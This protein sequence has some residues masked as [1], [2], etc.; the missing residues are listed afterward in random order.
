MPNHCRKSSTTGTTGDVTAVDIH[1]HSTTTRT[2]DDDIRPLLIIF[3]LGD[4]NGGIEVVVGE[5]EIEDG[6]AVGFEVS[7]LEAAWSRLPT[8][9]E[10]NFHDGEGSVRPVRRGSVFPPC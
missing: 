2:P 8:V 1:R 10:E 6:V 5:C 4:A 7:R 3:G 9:E